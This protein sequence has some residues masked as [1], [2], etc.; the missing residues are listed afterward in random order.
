VKKRTSGE[1]T[2][3]DSR[4]DMKHEEESD[5]ILTRAELARELGVTPRTI[6]EWEKRG[7]F[8]RLHVPGIAVRYRRSAVLARLAEKPARSRARR[9]K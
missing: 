6:L 4:R 1:K 5:P 9:K 7:A 2:G 3:L 8:E